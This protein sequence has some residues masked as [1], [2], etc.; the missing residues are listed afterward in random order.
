MRVHGA[1][2]R[3]V[4]RRIGVAVV[5]PPCVVAAIERLALAPAA[6]TYHDR[7]AVLDGFNHEIGAVFEQRRIEAHRFLRSGDLRRGQEPLHIFGDGR[8]HQTDYRGRVR[9]GRDAMVEFVRVFHGPKITPRRDRWQKQNQRRKKAA[10]RRAA[11][12]LRSHQGVKRTGRRP[13]RRVRSSSPIRCRW[14]RTLHYRTSAT[15]Q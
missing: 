8:L 6:A 14:R 12:S 15:G 1:N 7:L 5:A 2:A 9:F 3:S 10:H 13:P 11:F 4:F